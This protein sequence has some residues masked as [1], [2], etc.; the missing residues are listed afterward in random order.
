[1]PIGP[2]GIAMLGAGASLLGGA[3]RNR[4]SSAQSLRQ[5]EFQKS[6]AVKARGFTERMSSTAH[7]REVR[8]LMAAG[9][10]PILSG[11]GGMGASTPGSPSPSGAQAPMQDVVTPAVSTAVTL[12]RALAEIKNLDAQTEFTKS[13]TSIA[14][15]FKD[16]GKGIGAVTTP[17]ADAFSGVVKTLPD[18]NSAKDVQRGYEEMKQL[19]QN[20]PS[21][22]TGKKQYNEFQRWWF[23]YRH[24]N[25]PPVH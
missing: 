2:F 25:L 23:E 24:R 21:G 16:I 8:D 10:N 4:A 18:V 11:T 19:F 14:T 5:M 20:K 6:E 15:P 7:Q 12:K 17:L 1:M 9:L 22:V 3:K 13:K